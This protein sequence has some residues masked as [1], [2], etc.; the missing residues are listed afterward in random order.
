MLSTSELP[1]KNIKIYSMRGL[2]VAVEEEYLWNG[3]VK[4][5]GVNINQVVCDRPN[6]RYPIDFAFSPR[7]TVKMFSYILMQRWDSSTASKAV[8]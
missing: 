5:D 2:D 6:S 8:K 1:I 3:C 4:K 7:L